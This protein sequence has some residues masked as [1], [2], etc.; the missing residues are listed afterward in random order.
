M[1]K[2]LSIAGLCIILLFSVLISNDRKSINKKMIVTG[3]ILE[4]ILAL[5]V[6]KIPFVESFFN[7]IGAGVNQLFLFTGQ[8]SSFLFGSLLDTKKTG[9]IFAFQ[10]LPTIVFISA[11]MSILYYYNIMQTL[12]KYLGVAVKK[13]LNTSGAE[14]M[15]AVANIFVGQTEAPLFV[16]PYIPS[17]TRSE[18]TAMMIAGMGSI[19]VG[20][21]A[22]Y[23]G[24]GISAK[25]LITAS[26]MSAPASLIIS[27][28]LYPETEKPA[29]LGK[30]EITSEQK[31][32]TVI[33]AFSEATS[34]GLSLAL[35]VGAMLL[36]FLALI[37]LVNSLL[38]TLGGFIGISD[39]NLSWI[40]G[41]LFAPLAFIL[42]IPA[43]EILLAGN[44]LGQKLVMNEF[45]AYISLGDAIKSG[46]LSPRTITIMTYA[47]C[48]FANISSIGI[49]LGGIGGLA[50]ERKSD[51][52]QL[53]IKALIGGTLVTLMNAA[54]IG[55]LI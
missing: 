29:T 44:L 26:V 17:M 32:R 51:I 34:Q 41:R 21:M 24:L 7:V 28:I 46:A 45:V 11:F 14:T 35:N 6:L 8:G 20:A 25:H 30:I 15:N 50:P 33:E 16:R 39:L 10:I 12:I 2:L 22:G 9:F 36:T 23:V 3:L 18:I 43:N 5:A 42:G 49:Q 31:H 54:I 4:F 19:S 37:A 40:L 13:L 53:G 52:A 47:L 48:G 38:T 27:K 55:I 1:S